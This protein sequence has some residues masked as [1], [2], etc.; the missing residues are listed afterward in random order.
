MY[1]HHLGLSPFDQLWT[2]TFPFSTNEFHKLLQLVFMD[3]EKYQRHLTEC[4]LFQMVHWI[5]LKTGK[6]NTV[7]VNLSFGDRFIEVFCRNLLSGPRHTHLLPCV[8]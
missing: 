8:P 3:A 7:L 6:L 4:T 1:Y 2:F 5:C